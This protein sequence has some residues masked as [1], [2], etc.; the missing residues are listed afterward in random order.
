MQGFPESI[1]R[2]VGIMICKPESIFVDSMKILRWRLEWK[3][4]VLPLADAE[5]YGLE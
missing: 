2:E 1:V 3:N 4:G 5:V